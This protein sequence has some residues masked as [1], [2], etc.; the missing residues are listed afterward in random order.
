MMEFEVYP[1]PQELARAAALRMV[2]ALGRAAEARGRAS[3][4]LSGGSTPRRIYQLMADLAPAD[5]WGRVH[6]FWGDDRCVPGD[7]PDSNFRLAKENLFDLINPAP[8]NVHPM[9]SDLRPLETAAIEYEKE[10]VDFFGGTPEFDVVH[11]GLGTDGHTAS[12]FPGSAALDEKRAWVVGLNPPSGV[13]PDLPRL[14][15][16]LPAINAARL[17][18]FVVGGMEKREVVRGIRDRTPKAMELFPAARVAPAADPLW[19]LDADA[20]S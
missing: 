14:T 18:L 1:N 12:L 17:V 7:H 20:A 16:T 5:L 11:L 8:Q 4:A 13:R 19:L 3:L 6:F 15:L 10:L 2:E 9:P